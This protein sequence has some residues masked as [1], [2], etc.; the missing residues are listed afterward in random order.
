MR[1][2]KIKYFDEFGKVNVTKTRKPE[3]P[4]PELRD[5]LTFGS[6]QRWM[7]VETEPQGD[8]LWV[9]LISHSPKERKV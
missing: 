7:V 6:A 1:I 4:L 5:L 3:Q 8:T 9:W 2:T